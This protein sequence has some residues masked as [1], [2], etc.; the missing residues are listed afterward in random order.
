MLGFR[1]LWLKRAMHSKTPELLF[2]TSATGF[3]EN[4]VIPYIYFAE[5]H[6]PGSRYEFIVTDANRF[7]FR[8][9]S[10]LAWL[11]SNL[12]VSP[13]IRSRSEIK[14][15]PKMENSIRFVAAPSEIAKYVYIGDVD[16]MLLEGVMDWHRPVFDA[17]LPYSNVVRE[18]SRKLT[19]LHLAEYSKHY[20][21]GEIEDLVQDI[22]ND[23]ELLYAIVERK[24]NLY[25]M[26][27]R[28]ILLESRK[29]N[30]LGNVPLRPVHGIH[31]SL[32]RLPFSFNDDRPGW[33][34]SYLYAERANAIC[35]SS[36]FDEFLAVLG[37]GPKQVV[38]NL[39]YLSY[40]ICSRGEVY[41]NK[42]R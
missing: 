18:N 29:I 17:G 39:I 1:K 26:S 27:R 34:I 40:A 9:A 2:Y 19:G 42:L 22:F 37:A 15:N 35:S 11:K 8:N 30:D 12:G 7:N 5:I 24:G 4:F 32:N 3:Y 25:D 20:P 14:L 10:A 21:L 33:G 31:M 23:E 28:N 16:I 38:A 36:Q 41:F 6:N 13:T